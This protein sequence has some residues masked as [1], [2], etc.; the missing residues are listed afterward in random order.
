MKVFVNSLPKSGTHLLGRFCE[1]VD[2]KEAGL[3]L[4]GTLLRKSSR[5]FIRNLKLN[6][7]KDANGI[8]V[9]LDIPHHR[10]KRGWLKKE[11]Q[12]IPDNSYFLGHAPYSKELSAL[13]Q[14]EGVKVLYIYR[15][16][17]DVI[18]SLCNHFL[19]FE[20]YPFHKEFTELDSTKERILLSLKGAEK[21]AARLA[22]FKT[23]LERSAGW[24]FDKSV[25]A[26][27]FEELIGAQGGGDKTIQKTKVEEIL[28]FLNLSDKNSEEII[29]KIF[30][31]KA[32]TFNKGTINQW[33]E[34]FDADLLKVYEDSIS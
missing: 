33:K 30:Y 20:N 12:K 19:K 7:R 26:L 23:R 6:N 9:D 14:E 18:I 11:I 29:N 4:S 2:L 10:I 1:L 13:L 5:N 8:E 32:K 34:V 24:K 16:P 22:P 25:Y 21:G 15:E 27:P 17:K 3:H 31:K 28:Q